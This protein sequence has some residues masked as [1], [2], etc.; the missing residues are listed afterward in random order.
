MIQRSTK[1][2]SMRALMVDDELGTATTEGRAARALVQEMQGRAIEVVEAISA[3]DGISVVTSDSAIHVVLLDWN[4]GH[5][6][7]HKRARAFLDFV[8]SRNDKIPIFLM[9]ERGETSSIPIEMMEMVDEFVWTLEDTAAFVGGRV[10][11]AVRRYLEVMMPPLAAALMRFSQEYEYSWHTPGHTGGTAFLKSPV[12]RIFFDYFGEN[13]LRSDLSISVGSLG[14]LLDHSGPMGEHEKY[15]ARVFGAHRTYSVT[16]GT[17]MS[18]R[19]IFMAAVARDQIALCDRN[20]HKSI[21]HSLVMTGAIPQYLV[22]LRNRYGII[23]PI[24]PDRLDKDAIAKGIKANPLVTKGVSP[25]A[26][27]SIITNSTYDGLCYSA[28]RLTELLDPSVDRI[29]FDEAW[30][31]YARFN[32]LYRERHAMHG[33]PKDHKGPTTFATHSTHKLLAALSQASFLHIRDGR[34]PIPHARFNESYMLHASTSPLY[35]IIVSNDITAAMMDGPGGPTLT[36]ESIQEAVS[37]RQTMG[38]VR[39]QFAD[40]NEWFFRA[41]N[42]DTIKST[43]GKKVAFEEADPQQLATDPQCWVLHP[44]DTWHGFGD[45]EDGYCMLDPIKV[46]IVTPGVA[47]QGGLEKSGIPANLVTAYLHYRG[48]EVEKTTDFTILF[49]FSIGITKGKWG[50]LLNAL[51]DF[52]RDYDSNSPLAQVLPHLVTNHPIVYGGMGLHDL[53]D[54]M[55][56]Q[57]RESK[58]THWLAEAFSTLPTPVMSPNLAFQHLVRDEIEHVPLDQLADRVLATSVVPYP[59]GIPMLMP[60]ES[61]GANDGPYLGYLRALAAWDKRFPGF[62]HDTHGVENRDGVYY[63]QCLR[64]GTSVEANR[65]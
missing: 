3:D 19:V 15:A 1:R 2:I 36:N 35:P 12:G 37:F 7:Q 4:L 62:G 39:K 9:A 43:S 56:A 58:Q 45:L 49:L 13:M 24:P 30:Y 54:Q 31:A 44:G 64:K 38:R 20:C 48:V 23:G 52:K 51:L 16:N 50:T 5:D 55:F 17:S 11:A 63:V 21:E 59:P 6:E 53:A 22:P 10:A 40:K 26:V 28:K 57:L 41:W 25:R 27:H 33:D 61:T 60:G 18:N 14:S 47:D 32:P 65:T 29:H 42:A 34:S 8:R 46:S